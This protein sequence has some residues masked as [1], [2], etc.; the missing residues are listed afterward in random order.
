MYTEDE[1]KGKWCPYARCPDDNT[2]VGSDCMMWRW[3]KAG[4]EVWLGEVGYCGLGGKP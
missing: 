2:C 4:S 3:V 1:A